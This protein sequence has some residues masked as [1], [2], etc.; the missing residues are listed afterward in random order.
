MIGAAANQ[1]VRAL[2]FEIGPWDPAGLVVP[3]VSLVL[4]AAA[5]C[6]LPVRRATRTD[7]AVML[8]AE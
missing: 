5:A 1:G 6:Y 7:P 3:A 8:R 4:A 2:L